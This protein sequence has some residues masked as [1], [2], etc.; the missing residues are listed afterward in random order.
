MKTIDSGKSAFDGGPGSGPNPSGN[1]PSHSTLVK[2]TNT[3]GHKIP[4]PPANM[5]KKEE[6]AARMMEWMKT[7]R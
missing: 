3:P 1:R 6:G 2:E 7:G 5:P 4:S